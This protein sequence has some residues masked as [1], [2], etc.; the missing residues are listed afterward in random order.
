MTRLVSGSLTAGAEAPTSEE[1]GMH[2]EGSGGE[3]VFAEKV[4]L[5]VSRITIFKQAK[6]GRIPSFRSG[7]CVRF[8][9]VIVAKRLRTM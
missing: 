4:V 3:E 5:A 9:P 7:A 1:L 6:A 2:F 8:D